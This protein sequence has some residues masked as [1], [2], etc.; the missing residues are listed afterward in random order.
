MSRLSLL[1]IL[2][3][4]V[5][6]SATPDSPQSS[7]DWPNYRGPAHDNLVSSDGLD[8]S[9]A[10][11]LERVDWRVD[12]GRGYTVVATRHGLAY[13]AG[14]RDG[15]DT[16]RCVDPQT[17]EERWSFSYDHDDYD[18]IEPYSRSNEGGPVSTPAIADGR[19]FHTSRDG[20]IFCLDAHSG[21]LRWQHAL[22]DVFEIE[23]P[24]WGFA[25]SP[26]VIDGVIYM[27]LGKVV[28]M[29]A[30]DG[31]VLWQT[32]D[33]TQSYST[34]TPFTYAG[35]DLL[36]A[37]PLDG[38]V[39]VDRKT[40]EV[41][42]THPWQSNQPV[43]AA[44]PVVFNED[45][46]FVS[47]G[48]GGGAAM[49]RFDGSELHVVW[50]SKKM[51]NMMTTSV[52]HEG[53]L[54]G[55]D[56]KVLRCLDAATGEEQWSRRGLGRGS[57]LQ[58]GETMLVMSEAGELMAAPMSP[59]AFEPGDRVKLIAFDKVWSGPVIANGRLYARDP[60]G[61]LICIDLAER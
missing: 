52:I 24:R 44:S 51:S 14:W 25:A 4:I 48:W 47:S 30:E 46:L 12:V 22:T 50:E 17:G 11:L 10:G 35:K 60:L 31:Q 53:Y 7:L 5:G 13:T 59:K 38:L 28:A 41:L 19:V 43:N 54:Y 29:R 34:P 20:R 9:L 36:A 26:V 39:I 1:F 33:Y 40:G 27:D 16:V 8:T 15:R 23:Q 55:F 18:H 45:H 49:L 3:F 56:L 57:L 61:E 21:K 6:C 42:A 32:A 2:V 58:V 37:F